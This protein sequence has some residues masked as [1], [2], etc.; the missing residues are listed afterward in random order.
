MYHVGRLIWKGRLLPARRSLRHSYPPCQMTRASDDS[1]DTFPRLL[2][3]LPL[4]CIAWF[5][6]AIR[7]TVQAPA[8]LSLTDMGIVTCFGSKHYSLLPLEITHAYCFYLISDVVKPL[9][10]PPI[11]RHIGFGFPCFGKSWPSDLTSKL[12]CV[13][14]L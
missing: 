1:C 12:D 11:P 6:E 5:G 9:V 13:R 14:R 8:F 3:L 2:T 10:R 7:L 4:G